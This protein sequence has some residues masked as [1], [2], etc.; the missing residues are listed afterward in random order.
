MTGFGRVL[1]EVG[2]SLMLGGNIR[3]LTR[4]VTTAITLETSQG[5]FS[6]AFALGIVLLLLVL[7]LNLL[8]QL[9][10]GRRFAV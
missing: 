10:G 6:I 8:I 1:S 4:T 5:R 7:I 2:I 9:V 3:G